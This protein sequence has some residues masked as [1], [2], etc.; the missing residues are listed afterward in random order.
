MMSLRTSAGHGCEEAEG[1]LQGF[2]KCA[3]SSSVY[4]NSVKTLANTDYAVAPKGCVV[5][6]L[7]GSPAVG[8]TLSLLTRPHAC[9]PLRDCFPGVLIHCV[10]CPVCCQP[11]RQA[12]CICMHADPSFARVQAPGGAQLKRRAHCDG[13]F[14]PRHGQPP[15]PAHIR[16][17]GRQPLPH[18]IQV[19]CCHCWTSSQLSSNRVGRTAVCTACRDRCH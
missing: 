7:T 2:T 1:A 17:P 16:P 15:G 10:T 19:P 5:P 9:C 6:A 11:C 14:P 4:S 3:N 18:Q 12:Q 13:A 8:V